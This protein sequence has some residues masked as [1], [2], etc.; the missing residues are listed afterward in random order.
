MRLL[1]ALSC[2]QGRPLQQACEELAPLA[3]GLQ[4]TPGCAP[5]VGFQSW[6]SAKQ[7]A[8]QT[9]HGFTPHAYRA[10]VWDES[11]N[12]QGTW[13]SVHP[14]RNGR[15]E[16]LLECPQLPCIEVMYPGE[17]LGEGPSVEAAMEAGLRLA[18]DVSHVYIQREQGAMSAQTWE[19]LQDYERVSEIHVSANDGRRDRHQPIARD[20]F[21]LDWARARAACGTPI[22]LEAYFHQ[23]N[24]DQRRVQV[25]LVRG[26]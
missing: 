1:L 24:E 13:D 16:A 6:L 23:L 5:T 9:H 4:L 10:R 3:D 20:T 14:P 17:L 25:A 11:F 21:G 8:T 15:L 12:V 7:I 18:I 19:R 2:L 22:V 26:A